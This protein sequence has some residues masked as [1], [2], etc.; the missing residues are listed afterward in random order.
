MPNWTEAARKKTRKIKGLWL[1]HFTDEIQTQMVCPFDFNKD[2]YYISKSHSHTNNDANIQVAQSP[3]VAR[4]KHSHTKTLIHTTHF[5]EHD[6][7]WW[8][9]R[10]TGRGPCV[11]FQ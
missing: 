7:Q 5:L 10:H 11:F 3:F 9:L 6:A 4:T 1:L 8:K 2:K